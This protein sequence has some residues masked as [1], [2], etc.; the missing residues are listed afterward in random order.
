MPR[1]DLKPTTKPTDNDGRGWNGLAALAALALAVAATF[2]IG[3]LINESITGVA[4]WQT[5]STE[6]IA[7]GVRP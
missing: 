3:Y 1:I 2:G 6:Q 7:L 4:K 5:L